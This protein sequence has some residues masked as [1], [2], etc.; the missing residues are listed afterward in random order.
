M[1]PKR[2]FVFDEQ[3]TKLE[4]R[5]GN[6]NNVRP[7]AYWYHYKDE[8]IKWYAEK[9]TN[10][11]YKAIQIGSNKIR[12]STK[13]LGYVYEIIFKNNVFA[14][15]TEKN[16]K[17]ILK[18]DNPKTFDEF[19]MEYGAPKVEGKMVRMWIDYAKVRKDYA[20]VEIIPYRE[21]KHM[22]WH[23]KPGGKY[24]RDIKTDK[25]AQKILE[26]FKIDTNKVSSYDE[27]WYGAW[28]EVASGFIWNVTDT[29][30]M[31]KAAN[32]FYVS[33]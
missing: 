32:H 30:E 29:I 27:A 10:V 26:H 28:D 13:P 16:N 21:D 24:F 8:W 23:S 31:L 22:S 3:I 18:I 14:D 9:F 1:L 4:N 7:A 6:D 11:D 25:S 17:K 2:S 19:V 20:G 15:I 33:D 5:K 12:K